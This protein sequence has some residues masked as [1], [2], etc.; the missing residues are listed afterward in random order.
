MTKTNLSKIYFGALLLAYSH[1]APAQ[2]LLCGEEPT[3]NFMIEYGSRV[4]CQFELYGDV[5]TF[6]FLGSAGDTVQVVA[7]TNVTSDY[8]DFVELY[9]PDSTLL[10]GAGSATAA[11]TTDANLRVTLAETGI[12]TIIARHHS[13]DIPSSYTIELPCL[14]GKCVL[15][16]PPRATAYFP[17]SPCR[18]V[19]T[20]YGVGGMMSEGETRHFRS[21]GDVANQNKAGG[22]APADY[23]SECPFELGEHAAVHLN[24]TIVPMGERGQ[25]GFATIWPWGETQPISSWINYK[26]GTQNIANAGIVKTTASSGTDPDFSVYARRDLHLI[27]DVLGYFTE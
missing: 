19:D 10:A 26:A 14:A 17:V 7:I 20:R 15:A 1:L 21:Y 23:P 2:T 22:G 8:F 18:I 25:G 12:H 16:V 13:G 5:D 3:S 24:V 11:V 6:S 4:S 27:I 9:G